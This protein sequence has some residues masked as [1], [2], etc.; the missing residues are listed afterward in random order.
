MT[1]ILTIITLLFATPAWAEYEQP[2]YNLVFQQNGLEIRDYAPAVVVE[3]QVVA[4]RRDAAGDAF[5][6]L[7][8]YISGNNDASLEIPMTSPVAQTYAGRERDNVSGKWAVRF[9]LPRDLSA[10]AIPE[11]LQLGVNIVTLSAQRFA[12]VSFKGTQ[13]DKKVAKNRARLREFIAQNGYRV[14]G[15][16]VYAFYDPPF[17]PWFLRDNE[18]LLPIEKVSI[19]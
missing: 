10:E 17:V 5:R 9:F 4:S 18:I 1:R 19:K 7:F 13:N 12:S 6:S 2:S 11:P 15:Q 16:P 3:T 8:N 14:S